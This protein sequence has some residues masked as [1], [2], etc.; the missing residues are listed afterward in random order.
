MG[1]WWE[2]G[3]TVGVGSGFIEFVKG[4]GVCFQLE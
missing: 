3:K 2:C 4:G 1:R